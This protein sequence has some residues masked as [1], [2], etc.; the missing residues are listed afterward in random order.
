MS[1]NQLK[2]SQ[3]K[4]AGEASIGRKVASAV[5]SAL[6]VCSLVPTGATTA[7]ADE[8]EEAAAAAEAQ[9]QAE[10]EAAAQA[11]AEA[12]AQAEAEAQ[13]QAEAE[14][15]AAAAAEAKAAAEAQAAAEAAAQAEA[16]AAA[17]EQAAREQAER[18]AAAAAAAEAEASKQ[19]DVWLDFPNAY[20][21]YNNQNVAEPSTHVTVLA[22]EDFKFTATANNGYDLEHVK[23]VVDGAEN[24]VWP[25]ADGIYTIG[26]SDVAKSPTIKLEAV[27]HKDGEQADESASESNTADAIDGSTVIGGEGTGSQNTDE[28]NGAVEGDTTAPEGTV[29]ETDQNADDQ[30]ADSGS[31]PDD[32]NA[33]TG[34]E[35]ADGTTDGT[36]ADGMTEA[37]DADKNDADSIVAPEGAPQ[38]QSSSNLFGWIANIFGGRRSSIFSAFDS[39]KNVAVDASITLNGTSEGGSYDNHAWDVADAAVATVTK[40]AD[41]KSATVTGIKVGTT[42]V[43]HTYYKY[44]SDEWVKTSEDFTVTVFEAA[45]SNDGIATI[46]LWDDDTEE[47]GDIDT[48]QITGEGTVTI[49]NTTTLGTNATGSTVTWTSSDDSVATV[50]N[51]TVTGVKRGAA[52]ITANC[53]VNGKDLQATKTVY[54]QEAGGNTATFVPT[55]SNADVVYFNW[56]DVSDASDVTL[57]PVSGG[58]LSVPNYTNSSSRGYIVFF[59]KPHAN[60][61]FTGLNA[62]GQ[63]DYYVV[64]SGNYGNIADYPDLNKVVA[65]AQAAGYVGMFGYRRSEGGNVVN[66]EFTVNCKKPSL[67]ISAVSNK[68]TGVSVG[69]TLEFTVTITPQAVNKATVSGVV[70]NSATI[71]GK[72]V[73]VGDL[74][75]SENGVYTGK[76]SYT[77]TEAD[78]AAGAVSLRVNAS[79]NYNTGIELSDG[80]SIGTTSVV[81]ND[82]N[83]ACYFAEKKDVTYIF[84]SGTT[85]KTLPSEVTTLLPSDSVKYTPGVNVTANNVSST[86]VNVAGGYWTWK[87]WDSSTKTMT[88][89]G[90]VFTGTWEFTQNVEEYT[91]HYYWNGTTEPLANDKTGTGS[92]GQVVTENPA[93]IA[94]CTVVSADAQTI[95]LDDDASKNVITFYYRKN[96]TLTANS[97][98]VTYNGGEQSV[99]GYSSSIEGVEFD[100]VTTTGGKGTNAG[101]YTHSFAGGTTDKPSS[102]DKYI[103]TAAD[104]GQLVINPVTDEVTI[105]VTGHKGGNTYTG[106]VQTV[107]GYDFGDLPTGI[108][109]TDIK[110]SG[111]D[112]VSG[113]N[114]GTYRM[115]LDARQF[116]YTGGN[117]TNVKFDVTDGELAIAQKDLTLKSKDLSKEYDGTALTNNGAALET[118]EGWVD[119]EGATYT[120]TGSQ[121]LVNSSAN[122]FT[123]VANSG[124]NLSNYNIAKT[125]GQLTVTD[126]TSKYEVTVTAV[127]DTKTYNGEDQSVSGVTGTTYT[128]DKGATFTIEGLSASVTGKDATTYDNKV[129]GTAVV[130]DANGNDVTNQFKVNTVDGTLT[131]NKAT[132]RLESQSLTKEYDGQD[133]VNGETALKTNTGFVAGQ[134]VDVT[135]TGAQN[136]P[137]SSDNSFT[138]TAKQGTNLDNYTVDAKFGTLTVTSRGA[139]KE[140]AVEANSDTVIYDGNA[141]TVSGL[142]GA[143]ADGSIKVNVEGAEYTVTGLSTYGATGTDAKEYANNVY[144]TYKV[145]DAKGND[146]T[147]EFKVVPTDGKLTI[148]KKDVTL[149]SADLSKDYDG[150]AL[151]NDDTA[152]AT[153]EGFVEGQGITAT[154]TGS[155]TEVG[156]SANA[157]SYTANEGT[158]L[159][160][161]N[162]TKTEGTLTINQ[163]SAKVVVTIVGN[164]DSQKYSGSEQKVTGYRVTGIT[165]NDEATSLFTEND[166]QFTGSAT[167][168]GTNAGT[169]AMGL[170]ADQFSSTS[171]RF[172]AENV[173]FN[174][175]DGSMTITPREVTLT[176][177]SAEKTY[178]GTALTNGNVTV[179]GDGFVAGQGAT[180]NVT[181]TITNAGSVA[182]AFEY[183]LAEGTTAA[184]YTIYKAEGSLKVKAVGD[185]IVVTITGNSG[186]DNIYDGTAKTAEGYTVSI[187][188]DTSGKFTEALVKF[189][190]TAKV[191]KTDAGTY[192]MGLAAGQFSNA[193]ATNFPNV[194]FKVNDGKLKIAKATV[195][196]KSADLSKTYDGKALTNGE[197]KLAT[198][199][200]F[201]KGEGATYTFSGAQ[202]VV[203]SSANAFTYTLNEGTKAKNY[204]I[205]KSEGTLTVTSRDA[206]YEVTVKA[207]SATA[208]YD[209]QAHEAKGVE[210][211]EFTVDGNKY[212]VSG[213]TTED[214]SKTD[215]GTYTNNVIGTPVVTD[216]AD[217]VVTN[218]FQ[219]KT[220]NGTLT[221]NKAAV[222]LKSASA[223]KAY[224]GTELTK[225]EMDTISGFAKGEGVD[226]T[227]TGTI[228]NVGTA[229]NGYTYAAQAGT[230]LDNYTITQL[231]G[232]LKV[233]VNAEEVTV[234]ITGNTDSKKYNGAEQSVSGYTVSISNELYTTGDFSAP[235]QSAAVARG[236]DASDTAYTMGLAETQ[237]VNTSANFSNVKFVVNDGSLTINKLDVTLTSEGGEKAYDGTALT[238]PNVTYADGSDRFVAGEVTNLKA[239]G[240]VINNGEEATNYITYDHGANYKESNYNVTFD[241]GT[242]KIT[243]GTIDADAVNWN[244]QDVQK[245]YDGTA[246]AAYTATATDK[247]GNALTVEYQKSDGSWTTNPADITITHYGSTE[248]QL[249]A[250]GSNYASG[251]YTTRSE[252]IAIT[253]RPVTFTSAS[254]SKTYDG[255]A[256]TNDKVTVSANGQGAGFVE[257]EGAS[258]KVTGTQTAVG[259]SKNAFTYSFNQGTNANDYTVK[260]VEGDLTVTSRGATE[261]IT[262]KSNGGTATYDGQAH[263]AAGFETLTFEVG[264]K[265]YTVSGL[266]TSNPSA[267][268]AGNYENSITGTAVVKDADGNDVSSEF[269]VVPQAGSLT[270]GARPVTIV[271]GSASKAYNGDALTEHSWSYAEGS[272][273]F[274]GSDANKLQ[275]SYT[276]TITNVGTAANTFTYNGFAEGATASNYSVTT[277]NGTLEI[278]AGTIDVN[279]VNWGT[280]SEQKA[281]DGTPL[282][283]YAATATDGHGNKLTVEYSTDGENWTTDPSAITL[284]HSGSTEVKLRATGSNYAT[285]EYATSSETLTITKRLVTFTSAT[286]D[287]V[288]DGKALTNDSVTVTATGEGVGF[289]AG[290]GVSFNVT[291]SQTEAGSS[292]NAFTYVL[293]DGTSAGDYQI[294]VVPG[295]LTV[296]PVASKVTVT[297]TG[298]KTSDT[299]D[300]TAKTAEGYEVSISDASG[301][302]TDGN[303]AFNGIA[304]VEKTDAGTYPMG[305]SSSQFANISGNFTDVEFVVTDGELAI[306]KRE[307]ELTSATASKEYDG[308]ALTDSTVS[309]TKG[310]FVEGHGFTADVTGTQT[311]VGTSDNAFTYSLTGGATEGE[312]G[313]YA[314]TTK[315]GTLTVS[316][317]SEG[318][319]LTVTGNSG[320]E[321]YDGTQK[322]VG[323]ITQTEYT[324]NGVKYTITATTGVSGTDAGEYANNV[325]NIVVTDAS[326]ND[327]TK[328]F[329]ITP[330][331]G[332]LTINKATVTLTSA[333]DSREYNGQPLTNGNVTAE[334]FAKGEG[335]SYNVAGTITDAGTVDNAFT[336]T[337]NIGTRAE[338]YNITQN[339]GKLT[340][341]PVADAVKVTITGNSDTKA[342]NGVE[343]KVTGYTFSADNALYT[344][345]DF[346]FSG[347]A[348]AKGTNVGTYNM[349]LDAGQ[350]SNINT[351]NFSKVEFTVDD[352]SLVIEPGKINVDKVTWNK[353]DVQKA[354]DGTPLQAYTVS[355]TDE[356]GNALTVEYSTDGQNWTKDPSAITLTHYGSTNVQLRATGGNYA[357]GEFATSSETIAINKRLVTF[358]SATADKVYDAEAL[359]NDTITVTATGEGVGFIAGE[360]VSFNV[361]GSQTEAGQSKNTYDYSF[362]NGTSADDYWV[363]KNEG[364]LTVTQSEAEVVV[365]IAENSG[366]AVYDG[367][368]HSVSGY[369]VKKI[370]NDLYKDTDFSFGGT[371][372]VSGT[373]AGAY[374]M[375]LEASDFTN[376]NTNFKSVT[377]VVEDGQLI[378][379]KRDVELS[380]GSQE[381]TYTGEAQTLPAATGWEQSG[382]KGFVNGE[383]LDVHASGSVTNV[384]DIAANTVVWANGANFNADN[385]NITR[386][387]GTLSV[388]AKSIVPGEGSTMSVEAPANVKYNGTSQQQ[389]PVVKDGDKTLV[390]GEDYT[391][392]YTADT[393]NAGTV[394]V[395]ITGK[396]NYTGSTTTTYQIT[397]RSVTLTS[398]GAEKAYDGTALTNSNVTVTGDGFLAGEVSDITATGSI[399]NVGTATNTITYTPSDKFSPK[400]YNITTAEGTLSVTASTAEVTVT[401]AG[402][403]G[404][405]TY[406]GAEHT[407]TGYTVKSISGNLY[408]N[409]DFALAE[410]VTAS[411]SCTDVGTANMGLAAES[412]V[413]Q[414]QNFSNV[415]FV[416]TDGSIT[417][418]QQSINPDD[419]AYSG[420]IVGTLSNVMY[421]GTEHRQ[422]PTATKADGTALTEGTDYALEYS[423]DLTNAGDVVVVVNGAGNYTGTVYVGYK[424]TKRP[425]YVSSETA[426]K[427]YD[428]TALT[429]P[430][431]TVDETA[432]KYGFVEGD[433]TSNTATGSVTTVADGTKTNTIEVAF[434]DGKAANYDLHKTEGTLSIVAKNVTDSGMSVEKPGD[435]TYNGQSQQQKPVV[436]DGEKTLTEGE[437]YTLT[438]TEDTTN[439]GQVTVTITGT[440]NY[441]GTTTTTYQI[442][443]AALTVTTPDATKVYDGDALTAAG[444]IDGFV[445][446]ETA[447]FTTTGAQTKV[448]S[449]QNTYTIDWTGS[450]KEGNYRLV[451]ESVG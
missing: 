130:K 319:A 295:T 144:G 351:N 176:S 439:A 265:T 306:A 202:T 418:N 338:N 442:N 261:T 375:Q 445:N 285:G 378:V 107:S 56:H 196:L 255:N 278:M 372:S 440:G 357:T 312:N 175:T 92:Y 197:A 335:A 221:I 441:S 21:T 243:A 46:G 95:K 133:L 9:A 311:L 234:T 300:A 44:E 34:D 77:V 115:G 362:N 333:T 213:L 183:T 78:V 379:S 299:Y 49:G 124:T 50:S 395:T 172:S 168:A 181:G 155:Q 279:S 325:T 27:E 433:V 128:N 252:R 283:A 293:N 307:V 143:A 443:K 401:I 215:A 396:G 93:N 220:E 323:G 330:V 241:Q 16:E 68:T 427:T 420:V 182:N 69:D 251:Q 334:G 15:E 162:I 108:A 85:D 2:N 152:L 368:E 76:V 132:V 413:N 377:F 434:A 376:N 63:G 153:N 405:Y 207:N 431:V 41:G 39:S 340:V 430:D 192:A 298:N 167:A 87:G 146:V 72:S 24:E 345:N 80:A 385:Y 171:S 424:I 149:K 186:L 415:T 301:L 123:Y 118:E 74:S 193:D 256:L 91:V 43:T 314:I 36:A 113:T 211:Y 119:G 225:H 235:A 406:D 145:T 205:S 411:V 352:G 38:T 249:R 206:K 347:D 294:D 240:S 317:R 446:G 269:K 209:G 7:M 84:T 337:L 224:D 71:N 422:A 382:D 344:Q 348:T 346:K 111:T 262:V 147:S 450:A 137:G 70:V 355:A 65:A 11:E 6:L 28:N 222:T 219:V 134:G 179:T 329:K 22:R 327:V 180:Y 257:G 100:G 73:E 409:A 332:T 230:N 297:I 258:F 105:K 276:G 237:F 310:R 106:K 447:T 417:I 218:E 370:S 139:T 451:S 366:T 354:Y 101:T 227:Y 61:L 163:S 426:S 216:A 448:G 42:T 195:T 75:G 429:R 82:T 217:N 339:V 380:S 373:N 363:T 449:S 321:T 18:E 104:D 365:T 444:S 228:T 5:L 12:A 286:A 391:L 328:Q 302:Y 97:S 364:T 25:D 173:T 110:F 112:S 47:S 194:T 223:E 416:V 31:K 305:L 214:P 242:L 260:T 390:E 263:S 389:K 53:T 254:D 318:I 342:Y 190:G 226:V 157:F 90:I 353:Q 271:S 388:K 88:K 35:K 250:T 246:L 392:T 425:V 282:Q 309:V 60:H 10:A 62:D 253:A 267:T 383:V 304:K 236:A 281:Y 361:T 45:V 324:I 233:T 291:G 117:Y 184:N 140:I 191:E 189:G 177:G 54:V 89:D 187:S 287:K 81:T 159:D 371:A 268:D 272:E 20:I 367:T 150:S 437:D 381:F 121:T 290:E 275:L 421:D 316:D 37:T 423:A 331:A 158:N 19:V 239:N 138:W 148:N 48:L 384:G 14:A 315:T 126:R 102:D 369:T 393:T 231:Y 13:A 399:T 98:T 397:A 432:G 59:V 322:S 247:F 4:R 135:F 174:V 398:E 99:T 17:A 394:T 151:V 165:I 341:S 79:A 116:A 94:G 201:A 408:K 131:I 400:N 336:Y 326:G 273:Q 356:F 1:T 288:Y 129:T 170:A 403:T 199:T 52:T 66:A 57:Y 32:Q 40:G 8:L 292:S 404:T 277:Q 120:F 203:G 103:V 386:N 136:A 109:A 122:A 320:T 410:G 178:D 83:C 169:T 55:I 419:K 245:V 259:T 374:E 313:N 229:A 64:G 58:S 114:A 3:K 436:K 86:K 188:G 414:N 360:G 142:K 412:F 349:G 407:V 125:E 204:E 154:F 248:V 244:R 161:Y 160:N 33:G 266:T 435:V 96:V 387:E 232:E 264:G 30:N 166:I 280:R 141:H 359:T 156:S 200:G 296:N 29:S 238:K 270:I 208:T 185:A 284:T 308:T 438:Y 26:S 198:E 164:T 23:V 127:S 274:V 343:Q 289:I 212:T 358:T 67:T 303:F 402:N 51:G 350:F 210:S 428:G